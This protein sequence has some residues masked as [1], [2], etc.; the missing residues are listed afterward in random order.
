MTEKKSF[1]I[2]VTAILVFVLIYLIS[3]TN[4]IF[5][6]VGAYIAAIAVPIVGAGFIFY[7]TNPIV[8]WLQRNKIPRVLGIIVVF[9]LIVL[10]GFLVSIYIA[11]IVQKQFTRF[12]DNIPYMVDSV[13]RLINLWQNNQNIIPPQLDGTIERITNNLDTYVENFTTFLIDFIGQ[14]FGFV[15]SFF[16]IPFFLF[17]MLKDG[18]KL[19]PFISQ[20]LSKEKSSSF[21]ELMININH[22][23]A[24][25]IQGQFIV[26]LC[27]GVMLYIG[28][29][30]IGLPYSLTLALFSFIMNFI[31][32]LGPFL[33]AIPAILI[34]FFEDPMTAVW[35]LVVM[36]VAQQ[37]ES[38]FISPNVM[39]RVLSLHPLTVITLVLAAGGIAGFL[40]LIFII[41]AYAVIKTIIA[42]WYKEWRARQPEDEKDLI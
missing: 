7:V 24:S 3:L 12:V 26:S 4:F 17:F 38:N 36:V 10:V 31:P 35:A 5:V 23:L 13:E 21:K 6:P 39:G 34:G 18:H 22:T 16:L 32:F 1:R 37:I 9:L 29:V 40:G 14:I 28:Y 8:N 41:P 33:S 27:V 20:F 25:F 11:P 2:L 19:V 42:H 30:I 15:F